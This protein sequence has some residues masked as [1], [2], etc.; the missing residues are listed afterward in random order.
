MAY[1]HHLSITKARINL[2]AAVKQVHLNKEHMILVKEGIPIA[3]LID[4]DEFED[5]LELQDLKVKKDIAMDHKQGRH[6]S[7]FP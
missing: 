6:R 2:G 7:I 4:I 5:Y 3:A 1:L